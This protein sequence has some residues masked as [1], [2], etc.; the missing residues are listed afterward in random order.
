MEQSRADLVEC[1]LQ[2]IV[3][4]DLM[5]PHDGTRSWQALQARINADEQRRRATP[6]QPN[7]Q[8]RPR[9]HRFR[10]AAQAGPLLADAL[11]T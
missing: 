5:Q 9:Q 8:Q 2:A 11:G 10:P 3:R 6:V 7:K 4:A 1:V